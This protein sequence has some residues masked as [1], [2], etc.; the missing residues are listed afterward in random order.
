MI[1]SGE[2][3]KQKTRG[4]FF[5]KI[6]SRLPFSGKPD[7]TRAMALVKMTFLLNN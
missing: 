1:A 2:I 6:P 5:E 4:N 7:Y 3:I